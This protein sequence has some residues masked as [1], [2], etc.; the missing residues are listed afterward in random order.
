MTTLDQLSTSNCMDRAPMIPAICSSKEFLYG[1]DL[2]LEQFAENETLVAQLID[3][4]SAWL[5]HIADVRAYLEEC[6][7]YFDS[8]EAIPFDVAATMTRRME[9]ETSFFQHFERLEP[10]VVIRV[11]K[12][13]PKAQ[14]KLQQLAEELA[15]LKSLNEHC[16]ITADLMATANSYFPDN[17][18]PAKEISD[19]AGPLFSAL[20]A[21]FTCCTTLGSAHPRRFVALIVYVVSRTEKSIQEAC[22]GALHKIIASPKVA[23]CMAEL[24][25]ACQDAI[26]TIQEQYYDLRIKILENSSDAAL[27]EKIFIG[28]DDVALFSHLEWQYHR[29]TVIHQLIDAL[30]ADENKIG[31]ALTEKLEKVSD[32]MDPTAIEQMRLLDEVKN[33]QEKDAPNPSAVLE[34]MGVKAQ[35]A[36]KLQ[37]FA[38]RV[39]YDELTSALSIIVS[40][41]PPVVTIVGGPISEK[42]L[43]AAT[44]AL[45]Q[46]CSNKGVMS[47]RRSLAPPIWQTITAR[48][49]RNGPIVRME[50][51]EQFCDAEIAQTHFLA[52]LLDLIEAEE[53]WSMTDAHA[54]VEPTNK[55]EQHTLLFRRQRAWDDKDA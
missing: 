20:R 43:D 24:V 13:V 37:Q 22:G 5:S 32:L 18:W 35:S 51:G 48:S 28:V 3:S 4:V 17:Q 44:K 23:L 9:A 26:V 45:P 16:A 34:R 54:N 6:H 55:K 50:I 53:A 30:R 38:P 41:N 42:T 47:L 10:A 36:A 11:L 49:S 8:V 31:S 12:H 19:A 2:Q 21:I 7:E 1:T 14:S 25:V 29:C 27:A 15:D 39:A 33:I 52:T 40:F 46:C